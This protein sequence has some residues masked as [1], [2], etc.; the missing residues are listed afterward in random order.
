MYKLM[1][2]R[3]TR[4]FDETN[5]HVPLP[6]WNDAFRENVAMQTSA[7]CNQDCG[8]FSFVCPNQQFIT[9]RCLWKKGFTGS[10]SYRG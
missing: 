3:N 1:N 6:F 4:V 2:L 8:F 5:T 9:S 7:L 10:S